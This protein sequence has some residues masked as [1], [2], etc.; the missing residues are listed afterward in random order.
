M[1]AGSEPHAT[2]GSG[3][4]PPPSRILIV[5]DNLDAA[6]VLTLLLRGL[7][8]EVESVNGGLAALECGPAFHPRIVL[9]D[10]GMP[11]FDGFETARR[12]REQ[13]WGRSVSLV[14]VTGWGQLRDRHRTWEAGFDAHL[15]KPVCVTDLLAVLHDLTSS[16]SGVRRREEVEPGRT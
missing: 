11:G 10:L 3:R 7:G 5:D 1:L 4:V 16:G 12:I 8:H 9:L 14:A 2:S 6:D 15:V 13:P